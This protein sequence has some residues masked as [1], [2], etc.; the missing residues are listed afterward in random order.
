LRDGSDGDGFVEPNLWT[1]IGRA[2][3]GC[4]AAIV[5]D[6]QQVA[7]KLRR[8]EALGISSFILSGYPHRDEC[9][10]FARLVLPLL[11]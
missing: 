8:Y 5:G 1:G 3:S 11:R 2:R 4:G 7:A 10:R 6:P 9:E